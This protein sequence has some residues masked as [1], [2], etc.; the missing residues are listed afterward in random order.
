VAVDRLS[1]RISTGHKCIAFTWF[2][3]LYEELAIELQ[4]RKI[5]TFVVDSGGSSEAV[6]KTIEA[7]KQSPEPGVL[8]GTIGKMGR[9][10]DIPEAD[11]VLFLEKSW[12]PS[13]NEQA[14]RRA[15]RAIT[16]H[17]VLVLSLV[18]RKTIDVHAESVLREK[19][20]LIN[21]VLMWHETLRLLQGE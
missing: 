18:A 7:F 9:G 11:T 15:Y 21:E 13:D 1:E 16:T 6:G 3:G 5:L 2:R 8:V 4:K 14:A 19:T 17:K 12:V 20:G 10:W